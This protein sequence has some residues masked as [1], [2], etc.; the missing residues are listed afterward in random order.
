MRTNIK[1]AIIFFLFGFLFAQKD[2]YRNTDAIKEEWGEY[3]SYQKEEALSF[4]D[5]L[6][7]EGHYERCLLNAF[8]ILYKFPD[9]KITSVTNYYIGRCYEEM[10]NYELANTYYEKVMKKETVDSQTYKASFYRNVYCKLMLNE[11]EDVLKIEDSLTSS[12]PYVLTFKGYAHLK[13]KNW[14]EARTSFIS[15]Q[16]NFSHPHYDKLIVPLF[17]VIEDVYTV[18]KHNRYL[19]FLMS[20]LFPGAGQFMLGNKN[21]GQGILSSVGLM[22]LVSSWTSYSSH[23]GSSR[24]VDDVSSSVPIFKSYAKNKKKIGYPKIPDEIYISSSSSKYLIPPLLICSGVF[25]ASAY[26]SFTDT[27]LKNQELMNIYINDKIEKI[28]PKRFL[29]F[30]EPQL[31]NKKYR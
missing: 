7:K 25:I 14:G 28:S 16:S 15:A 2:I 23:T 6:F 5:F 24:A 26:K 19:I 4:C 27:K 8:Q 17:K 12:D 11:V 18:P 13:K 31:I 30:P 22:L 20:A 9:S 3:S 21:Q 1:Q 10:N 29:D